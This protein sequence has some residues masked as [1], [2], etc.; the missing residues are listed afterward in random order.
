ML[1]VYRSQRGQQ[2]EAGWADLCFSCPLHTSHPEV[3]LS[4]RLGFERLHGRCSAGAVGLKAQIIA[5]GWKVIR[6]DLEAFVKKLRD[7]GHLQDYLSQREDLRRQ[8]CNRRHQ[9]FRERRQPTY[10]P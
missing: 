4:S 2:A 3:H 9:P 7:Q 5:K 10:R 6:S 1:D 8:G